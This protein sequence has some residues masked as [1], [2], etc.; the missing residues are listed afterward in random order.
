MVSTTTM[1]PYA[2][3]YW[4]QNP[5]Y[6]PEVTTTVTDWWITTSTDP[7]TA[8]TVTITTTQTTTASTSTTTTATATTSTTTTTQTTTSTTSAGYIETTLTLSHT[9]VSGF[10]G[11]RRFNGYL[12]EKG[13]GNPIAGKAIVLTILSGGNGMTFTATTN[14]QGY[15]EHLF[16]GNNG[17]FTWAEARFAGSGLY[18][19]SFSG[20]VYP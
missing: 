2:P 6:P 1:F 4:W 15:Y 8:Y 12:R 16:T 11:S 9:F 10:T 20:R 18:L 3:Y 17:V 5:Y 7:T 13:T 14:G 19:P